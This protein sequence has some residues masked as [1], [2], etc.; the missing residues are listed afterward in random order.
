MKS[1]HNESA[2][3]VFHGHATRKDDA[4]SLLK[5]KRFLFR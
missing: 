2:V 3:A 4:G 5:E 1:V